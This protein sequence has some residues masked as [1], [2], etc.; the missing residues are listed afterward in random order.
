MV[1]LVLLFHTRLAPNYVMQTK[2][3]DKLIGGK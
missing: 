1:H 2:E 3:E